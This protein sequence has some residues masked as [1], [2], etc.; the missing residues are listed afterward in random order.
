MI[1]NYTY[2]AYIFYREISVYG[3]R[4]KKNIKLRIAKAAAAAL[5]SNINNKQC[6]FAW[7][8]LVKHQFKPEYGK[9]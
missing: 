2:S 7:K 8:I 6:M 5:E 3:K 1:T 9:Y 4:T